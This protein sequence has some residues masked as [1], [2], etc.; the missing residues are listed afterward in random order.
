MPRTAEVTVRWRAFDAN[1]VRQ[2]FARVDALPGVE[3]PSR[4][5]REFL[6]SWAIRE[7]QRATVRSLRRGKG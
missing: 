1:A 6:K 5:P 3:R 2:Y 4:N 7:R